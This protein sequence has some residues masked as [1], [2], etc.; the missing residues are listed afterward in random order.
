MTPEPWPARALKAPQIALRRAQHCVKEVVRTILDCN[1][2]WSPTGGGVRRYHLE[3]MR[4]FARRQTHRYV[5]LT[6]GQPPSDVPSGDHV[7]L[8]PVESLPQ[9]GPGDYRWIV[10]T[11]ILIDAIQKYRPDIIEVGSPYWL[12]DLVQRA[13]RRLPIQQRP[14]VVG[15]WHAD[16]PRT[17]VHRGVARF[18]ERAAQKAESAAWAWARRTYGRFDGVFVASQWIGERMQARGLNR[19]FWTPLGVDTEAFSPK[20]RSVDLRKAWTGSRPERKVLFFPHRLQ[21]EKGIRWLLSAYEIL[22]RKGKAPI[23]VIA[24][25]GP[26]RQKV[27]AFAR[28]HAQVHYVGYINDQAKLAAHFASA[29]LSVSL[30]AFET[31]GLSTA[32]S[33]ASGLALVAADQGGA[34]ELVEGSGCGDTVPY[35][36]VPALASSL[37]RLLGRSDFFELGV[38]GRRYAEQLTWERSID[39]QLDAHEQ[40]LAARRAGRPIAPGFYLRG[41]PLVTDASANIHADAKSLIDQGSL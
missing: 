34:A 35:G 39:R 11:K 27:Q 16:Y 4:E 32:E 13:L 3:K 28:R 2:L 14:I 20:H 19:L 38:K 10:R 5:F 1:N 36:N 31:F 15:F 17:Y 33:M 25:D 18:S 12:P 7:I 23:L 6:P 21:E 40:L 9:P 41:T 29:D 37:E 30:S 22:D 8:E 26:D 24:G